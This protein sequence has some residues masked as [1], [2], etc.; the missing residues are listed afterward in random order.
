MPKYFLVGN[1][2]QSRVPNIPTS[3]EPYRKMPDDAF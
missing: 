1:T 3:F 2:M